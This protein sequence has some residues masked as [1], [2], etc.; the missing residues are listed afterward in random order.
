MAL[1]PRQDGRAHDRRQGRHRR[2]VRCRTTSGRPCSSPSSPT[3][4]RCAVVCDAGARRAPLAYGGPRRGTAQYRTSGEGGTRMGVLST[5]GSSAADRRRRVRRVV[6]GLAAVIAVVATVPAGDLTASAAL[7]AAPADGQDRDPDKFLFFASDGLQQATVERYAKQGVVPGFRDLLRNGAKASDNGLLTQA[8][9]NTGAGWYTLTTGAWPG[10][11]GSTNNTFHIN[12]QPFANRTA[13]FDAGVLQ[14]ETLAQAAERGG[15]KVAQIEWAGGRNGAING[16]DGRLPHLPVRARRRHELHL[17]ERLGGVRHRLRPAVRPPGRLRRPGAV[18]PGG[19]HGRRSA[20]RTFPSR[21]ARR[22]RC[23][24]ACST[25]ASTSTASTPTSTTAATTGAPAT[26]G[27]CSRRRRTATTPSATSA[28]GQWAD[29][30][31]TIAGR[32]PST[33]RRPPSSSRSSGWRRT[34]RR[35]ACSTRR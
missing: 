15:K 11:H 14:A 24:C 10:V 4:G 18:P 20:G 28:Q 29:V 5:S 35:S 17:A 22:R 12:G 31:V 34:S 9:A 30:K 33:A 1:P 2:L 27:S 8:A 25:S 16:P 7:P 19:A 26:T 32:P 6:G 23:A 21:S 3:C 13:A